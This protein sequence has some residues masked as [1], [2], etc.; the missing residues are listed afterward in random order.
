MSRRRLTQLLA[1][2]AIFLTSITV[3]V[4]YD[5]DGPGPAPTVTGQITIPLPGPDAVVDADNQFEPAEQRQAADPTPID[6]GADVH[7]D[8]RDEAPPGLPLAFRDVVAEKAKGLGPSLPVGGAQT[9]SCR[10]HFL[11]TASRH[12]T[13]SS[14]ELEV[15]HYTVSPPGS[16]DSIFRY[17]ANP[18]TGASSTF[19]FEMTTGRCE[20]WVPFDKGP[21]TQLA[22]NSVSE[23]VEIMARG[24]EPRSWWLAQPGLPQ[25]AQ[26]IADR[27][28]ARGI[29]PRFVDP[30][31][32]DVQQAGWTDHYHLECGNT[33]HDVM[34]NFPYAVFDAM[35]RR[36]YGQNPP[37]ATNGCSPL[38]IQKAL[39][40]NGYAVKLNGVYGPRTR[41]AVSKFQRRA[42]LAVDGIVGPVTGRALGLRG[43][44]A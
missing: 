26:L 5:P 37:P 3:T 21:W 43:C 25:L 28:R 44:R 9:Y 19:G 7:E 38:A 16:L 27:L 6:E 34:P 4:V 20:Q 32:C 2:L 8:M 12:R 31:G 17:F 30:E 13:R 18:R 39:R 40:D 23:S 24:N 42:R 1:F 15:L 10:R 29:P 11:P 14:V 36:F 22:F 41:A 33:H 35:V